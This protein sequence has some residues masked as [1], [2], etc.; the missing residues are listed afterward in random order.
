MDQHRLTYSNRQYASSRKASRNR[1]DSCL[2][3]SLVNAS[4]LLVLLATLIPLSLATSTCSHLEYWDMENGECSPCTKCNKHQIVVRP[5]Q[6]HMDTLCKPLNSIEIDWSKSMAHHQQQTAIETLS[7]QAATQREEEEVI[8]DWQ[9][10]T[11]MLAVAA[12]L[13]FFIGTAF[14]SINYIRQWRRIKKQFDTGKF[15]QMMLTAHRNDYKWSSNDRYMKIKK[16]WIF[17]I[18]IH[19]KSQDLM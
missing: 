17:S 4:L 12:C 3:F 13:M 11:L 2:R 6:R 7:A 19:D 5:C 1:H 10:V 15:Y 18:K 9:L 8:W 14:I 16:G